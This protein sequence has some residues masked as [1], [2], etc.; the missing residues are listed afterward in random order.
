M[1]P[2]QEYSN[3]R[4]HDFEHVD[5][6][7]LTLVNRTLIPRMPWHDIS[8]SMEGGF[9]YDLERHFVE[10]WNYIR[11]MEVLNSL[12]YPLLALPTL[13]EQATD[14]KTTS[15]PGRTNQVQVVRSASFWNMDLQKEDSYYQAH[16]DMIAE[17][18]HF[19][20]I[21][22]Q[23]FISTVDGSGVVVNEVAKAIVDR[24]IL[25]HRKGERF[26]VIVVLP[27][28]PAFQGDLTKPD[29]NAIR[30][31]MYLQYASIS[32]NKGSVHDALI[33]AGINP[34]D[35][36]EWYS[37]RTYDKITPP[38]FE[39]KMDKIKNNNRQRQLND[40]DYYVTEMV[41]IHSKVLIVD[42]RKAM[43]GS[44]N[45]N[46]RSLLGGRDAEVGGVV[47]DSNLVPSFM[48]DKKYMAGKSILEF[49]LRLWKEH[50]GLMDVKDW[51]SIRIPGMPRKYLPNP[52]MIERRLL[53][54]LSTKAYQTLWRDKAKKN[55]LLYRELFQCIPDDSISTYVQHTAFVSDQKKTP[56][57][58]L[59]GYNK[60]DTGYNAT[61]LHQKLDQIQGH[62]V[63]FPLDYLNQSN[64][65]A[66]NIIQF[67][68]P[69]A[70]FT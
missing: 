1:F 26:K 41:Y 33:K 57:G 15:E 27:L 50:L 13:P 53:D 48:G 14:N 38:G 36:I 2:G 55:T 66:T 19:I 25:A 18:K 16:L 68:T 4:V 37:L 34:S 32:R 62:L 45:I 44:A 63:Q 5:N 12:D 28:L 29:S 59:V 39:S 67:F 31:I 69:I 49:R 30:A 10:R 3:P 9:T 22:N 24:I 11:Q 70:I 17:A 8:M 58:H 42:D 23:Y 65:I 21:E 7:H 52:D 61:T 60:T 56:Y 43:V 64:M 35:Y 51:T 46:D 6:P 20:Y 40:T 47:E 54:P